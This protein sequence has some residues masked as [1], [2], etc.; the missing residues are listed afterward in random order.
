MQHDR[1]KTFEED[2]KKLPDIYARRD[3]VKDGFDRIEKTL[4]RI[5][6][7]LDNKADKH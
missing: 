6:E 5:E 4:T 2:F 1:Q 3:D 7:K